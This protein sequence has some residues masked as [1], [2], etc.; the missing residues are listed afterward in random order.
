M[1]DAERE[2]SIDR[3]PARPGGRVTRNRCEFSHEAIGE[4]R[5]KTILTI[6]H[7]LIEIVESQGPADP[8]EIEDALA[9][10]VK[11]AV[12]AHL[13]AKEHAADGGDWT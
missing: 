13:R 3:V 5:K 8:F 4:L 7:P 9:L 2:I 1:T 11:W 12:R 10:L 6:D